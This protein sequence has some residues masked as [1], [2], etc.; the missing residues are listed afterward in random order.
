MNQE[1]LSQKE[2]SITNEYQD[3]LD[4]VRAAF[5]VECERIKD[6]ATKQ[7]NDVPEED[8]DGRR[9]ILEDQ[10]A[11][12]DKALSELKQL[13]AKRGA[14]VRKQLEEIAN[15]R[16]QGDFDLDS[17]LGDLEVDEKEHAA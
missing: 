16:E 10:K 14:E 1:E 8:E 3:F 2:D 12:L 5:N 13:L 11:K 6:E 9:R 17:E 4:K 7:F 15:L